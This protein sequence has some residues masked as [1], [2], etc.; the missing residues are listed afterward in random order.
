MKFNLG[1]AV[2]GFADT[3]ANN[4]QE[5]EKERRQMVNSLG[6][7]LRKK[8]VD[9]AYEVRKF[10]RVKRQLDDNMQQYYDMFEGTNYDKNAIDRLV[11]GYAEQYGNLAQ[12]E[13]A[14]QK[15]AEAY[16]RA[17]TP[18]SRNE[19][20][21]GEGGVIG[22][23]NVNTPEGLAQY[24]K[25][26]EEGYSPE[27]FGEPSDLDKARGYAGL[28]SSGGGGSK[29]TPDQTIMP[30]DGTQGAGGD[31]TQQS[32]ETQ[33][34]TPRQ[35]GSTQVPQVKDLRTVLA[36]NQDIIAKFQD[37]SLGLPPLKKQDFIRIWNN[38]GQDPDSFKEF[39]NLMA[40]G[41]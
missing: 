27:R 23:F 18:S 10:G 28:G 12:T 31:Q 9:E 20:L 7:Y 25:Y 33:V 16:K 13:L 19:F 17:S 30:A 34:P 4:I 24:N 15:A 8:G 41:N 32:G 29:Q 26:L 36:E 35:T 3:V 22:P 6:L 21:R 14:V 2:G 38:V 39:L 5:K 1:A 11:Y 37:G 40:Q